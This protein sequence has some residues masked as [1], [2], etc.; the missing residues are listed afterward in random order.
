MHGGISCLLSIR[1]STC[2]TA[3]RDSICDFLMLAQLPERNTI[4]RQI[5]Q[6]VRIASLAM[7]GI[8]DWIDQMND[9]EYQKKANDP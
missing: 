1:A 5:K 2:L 6:K 8:D 7:T 4:C 3:D 9:G